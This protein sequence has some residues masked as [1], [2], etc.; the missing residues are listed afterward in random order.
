MILNNGFAFSDIKTVSGRMS[1]LRLWYPKRSYAHPPLPFIQLCNK[2][3]QLLCE[4]FSLKNIFNLCF[5]LWSHQTATLRPFRLERAMSLLIIDDGAIMRMFRLCSKSHNAQYTST[6][7]K[8]KPVRTDNAMQEMLANSF[9]E[10][11]T[12]VRLQQKRGRYI[13][14]HSR[15]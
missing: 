8:A 2:K 5:Y 4:R 14:G 10:R 15:A 7:I 13:G 6:K 11:P 3:L 12:V 1:I 9:L